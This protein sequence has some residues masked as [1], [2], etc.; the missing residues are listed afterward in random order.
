MGTVGFLC[1]VAEGNYLEQQEKQP[2]ENSLNY[3]QVCVIGIVT[4]V[5]IQR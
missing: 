2:M 4:Q 3:V 1:D 5:E